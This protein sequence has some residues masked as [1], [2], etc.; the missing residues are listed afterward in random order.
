MFLFHTRRLFLPQLEIASPKVLKELRFRAETMHYFFFCGWSILALVYLSAEGN[1]HVFQ[2]PRFVGVKTGRTV[3]I[4][5]VPSDPSLPT[6]VEWFKDRAHRERLKSNNRITIKERSSYTN[7]SVTIKKVEIE[8]SG[9]YFCKLNG[10]LGPGTE[11][12][13]S[14]YS[15]AQSILQRSQVK[16][17]LIFLQAFL[18]ILCIVIPLGKKED[19]VY[20][21]PD[22]DHIYE[23]LGVGKDCD[24][25]EDISGYAQN[26][27]AA[28]EVELPG[29]E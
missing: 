10:T 3:L 9:V 16:D 18:L 12:Q 11:L 27:H 25:Y 20:E 22:Q 8:D 24:L 29:Q 17:V 21:E 2:K 13:V 1:L 26:T 7:A 23:G 5:C 14:R 28:W 6:H 4:Y 15:D 19:A